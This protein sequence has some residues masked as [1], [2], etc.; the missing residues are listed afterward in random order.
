MLRM[1]VCPNSAGKSSQPFQCT[2]ARICKPNP[3][4]DHEEV[5]LKRL[6]ELQKKRGVL[7]SLSAKWREI[8]NLLTDENNLQA[9]KME[10]P[11][12]TSLFRKCAEAQ[13]AYHAALTDEGQRQ[14]SEVKS[15]AV[16][17]SSVEQEMQEMIGYILWNKSSGNA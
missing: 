15:K 2:R 13:H 12:I 10:L 17:I 4:L 1:L 14:Q 9:V 5:S 6:R 8:D 3:P 7:S 11:E 16:W